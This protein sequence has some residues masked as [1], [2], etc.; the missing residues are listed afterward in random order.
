MTDSPLFEVLVTTYQKFSTNIFRQPCQGQ[1]ETLK[2]S[3]V[4]NTFYPS[5]VKG[6]WSIKIIR[7]LV[8]NLDVK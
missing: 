4:Y 3:Q 8:V 2:G 7:P 5:L 1:E 6:K